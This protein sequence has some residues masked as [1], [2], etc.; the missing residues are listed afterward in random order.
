MKINIS[1]IIKKGD[2]YEEM[3]Y[4]ILEPLQEMELNDGIDKLS[5][6]ERNLFLIEKLI[7]E[8]NNGGFDQYFVNTEE[9]YVEETLDTLK[10]SGISSLT[11]LLDKAIVIF[12]SE[13]DDEKKMDKYEKL[14]DK[15]YDKFDYD[16]FYKSRINYLKKNI[17]QFK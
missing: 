10:A 13:I 9:I 17:E 4:K 5:I 7:E 14:D 6:G 8:V 11:K 12:K 2:N 3:Y 15:F 16:E 1:E